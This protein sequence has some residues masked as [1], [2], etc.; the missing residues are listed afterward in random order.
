MINTNL[1]LIGSVAAPIALMFLALLGWRRLL[2]R[3]RRR[4]PLN[5]KL[6]NLPGDGLRKQIELR[7]EKL[8]EAGIWVLLAAP[9][10]LAA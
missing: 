7:D 3:D 6:L 1:I 4:S 10:M 8:F 2:R 9:L 5:F